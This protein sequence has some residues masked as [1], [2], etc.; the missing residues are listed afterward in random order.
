MGLAMNAS[1]MA[2][3][4]TNSTAVMAKRT[5]KTL[6]IPRISKLLLCSPDMDNKFREK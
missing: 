1:G 3:A 6:Q 5:Q 4:I 2:R